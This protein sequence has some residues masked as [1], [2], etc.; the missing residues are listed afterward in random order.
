[1][2]YEKALILQVLQAG[3]LSVPQIAAASSLPVYTVSRRLGDLEKS[4]S[5]DLH[6]YEGPVPKFTRLAA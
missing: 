5:V 6:S 2:E 3:P 4:G 1:M